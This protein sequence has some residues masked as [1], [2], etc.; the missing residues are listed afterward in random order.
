L[1]LGDTEIDVAEEDLKVLLLQVTKFLVPIADFEKSAEEQTREFMDVIGAD[2]DDAIQKFLLRADNGD[3]LV[4]LKTAEND[5]ALLDKLYANMSERSRKIFA[6]D[7][8]Y[9][10]EDAVPGSEVGAAIGRL[11]RVARESQ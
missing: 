9:E 10:Y 2:D 7:L 6:E 5:R 1:R 8:A 4:L 11:V 3:V